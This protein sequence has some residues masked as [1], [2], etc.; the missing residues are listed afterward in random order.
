MN[1]TIAPTNST[2]STAGY[3]HFDQ[4][5]HILSILFLLGFAF[6]SVATVV[7][8]GMFLLTFYKDP[9]KCLRTPSAIFIAGL[10]SANF[11][12]GLIVEPAF[13]LLIVFQFVDDEDTN[14]D[15][16]YRFAEAFS[17]VTI[18]SSFLI[19]L[20][21]GIVQYLL[22]KHPRVYQKAVSPVSAVIGVVFIFIYCI[23]FAALP[24]ITGMDKFAYY[25]V[26]LVVHNTLLTV[27][28]V[29]LYIMIYCAFRKLAQR[30]RDADL[31]EN[32]EGQGA[33]SEQQRR[34]AENEFVYGTIILT[35]VLII[36]VWPFCITMFIAMF[37]ELSMAVWIA[38][39][40][41]EFFL[42]WKFAVDPFVF[43]WRLRK[44]R[45]SLLL[46]MQKYCLSYKPSL[47][48]ATYKRQDSGTALPL[49]EN[50]DDDGDDDVQVTVVDGSD[51]TRQQAAIV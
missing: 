25:C 12:T 34:R 17:F 36:T 43:A 8:N 28:L 26:D 14:F 11:L 1:S 19:M 38:W 24:E 42:M 29:I 44:Y 33:E 23:F 13:V 51:P 5:F 3:D 27:V 16:F 15:S 22:I 46:V 20:A 50:D 47:P 9:L 2:N 49:S 6:L 10:T 37:H 45:K 39:M 35:V 30:H 41:T 48:E 32:S 40:V 7:T 21:L 18:T 4:K 31:E